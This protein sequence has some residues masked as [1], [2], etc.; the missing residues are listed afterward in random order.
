MS[1]KE[2]NTEN[3][4]TV[5]SEPTVA[6]VST[7]PIQSKASRKGSMTVEEYFTKVRKALDNQY[8]SL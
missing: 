8:E 6:Y 5:A 3:S 7:V 1:K 2:Y 4:V